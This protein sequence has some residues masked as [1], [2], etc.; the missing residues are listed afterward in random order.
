[1]KTFGSKLFK[2]ES[3]DKEY[4]VDLENDMYFYTVGESTTTTM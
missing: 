1:M 4:D 3:K 2:E